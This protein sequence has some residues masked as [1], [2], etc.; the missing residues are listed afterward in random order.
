MANYMENVF[1]RIRLNI[2]IEILNLTFNDR[3]K[4][5]IEQTIFE[6]VLNPY[7][8]RDLD[9]LTGL[10]KKFKL[11]D[12]WRE[13]IKTP[14]WSPDVI[15]PGI[16]SIYTIPEGP[17]E[18]RNI[19]SIDSIHYNALDGSGFSDSFGV[20]SY[21]GQT[22]GSLTD[23]VLNSYTSAKERVYPKIKLIDFNR[24]FVSCDFLNI[25][26]W[27]LHCT[28]ELDNEFTNLPRAALM[29][30][31]DLSVVVLKKYIYNNLTVK[32]ANGRIEGGL[33]IPRIKEIIDGYSDL[34]DKYEKLFYDFKNLVEYNEDRLEEYVKLQF[35]VG[36]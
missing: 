9:L 28:L 22:A 2:P 26:E 24:V 35:G 25:S 16:T 8:K 34:N 6:D 4:R 19:V 3:G 5:S 15:T 30:L 7:L 33:E 14:N 10:P 11:L 20:F 31:C 29:T 18:G 17:R 23:D 36:F 13:D 21:S 32:L 27:V 12:E 1:S